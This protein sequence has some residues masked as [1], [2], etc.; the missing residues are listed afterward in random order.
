M[1]DTV[2][3][4]A[5]VIRDGAGRLLIARR[6]AHKRHGGLW[7]FPGGKLDPGET[8]AGAAARELAEELELT[9]TRV[10]PAPVFTRRDPGQ[11]FRILFVEVEV[12]SHET[13]RLHEHQAVAWVEVPVPEDYRLA[14]SDA[15]FVAA[16]A[17]GEVVLTATD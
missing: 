13:I 10:G 17:R 1:T 16:L 6:P 9:A 15:D 14:P 2:D 5:A 12:A 4:V 8:L 7:E 11:P 3:V